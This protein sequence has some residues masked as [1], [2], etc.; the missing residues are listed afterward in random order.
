MDACQHQMRCENY[1][2]DDD[3]YLVPRPLHRKDSPGRFANPSGHIRSHSDR[4]VSVHGWTASGERGGK[5][6]GP[7]KVSEKERCAECVPK[8]VFCVQ[9]RGSTSRREIYL[10]D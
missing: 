10:R 9:G 8:P 2:S 7:R 6:W 1:V 3:G 4:T 5:E